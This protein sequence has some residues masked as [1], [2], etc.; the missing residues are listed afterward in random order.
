MQKMFVSPENLE[1]NVMN[2]TITQYPEQVESKGGIVSYR[3]KVYRSLLE[4]GRTIRPSTTSYA[5]HEA[6]RRSR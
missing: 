4:Q 1:A 2:G 6:I 5:N 3:C